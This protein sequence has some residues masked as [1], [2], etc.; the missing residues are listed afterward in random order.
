[1]KSFL[2]SLLLL[3]PA[4]ASAGEAGGESVAA[5]QA[6]TEAWLS[7]TDQGQ[8]DSSWDSAA[9][10]LQAAVQK[11]VWERQLGAVRSPLGAVQSRAV[12]SHEYTTSLPGAPDGEYV[13]FRFNTRFD[14][15]ANSVETVTAMLGADGEWRV[16]GYFIR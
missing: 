14:H 16:A 7:L 11:N 12:A 6:A 4:M 15:K 1:M 8:F 5:A 13:V 9:P 2:W 3:L 10:Y